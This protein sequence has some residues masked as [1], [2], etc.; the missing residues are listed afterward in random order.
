MT[1]WILFCCLP[2]FEGWRGG[3]KDTMRRVEAEHKGSGHK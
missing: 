1:L 2:R 3:V